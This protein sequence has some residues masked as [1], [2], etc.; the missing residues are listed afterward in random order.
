MIIDELREKANKLPLK[1]GVYIM[2]DRAGEVIYVGKA[3]LLKN[4]VTSYFRGESEGK[5]RALVQKIR[6]FN[7]IVAA[8]EFEALVL[9]N[10]LIKR[11]QPH[12]NILLKDS[13]AYP[14]V[15]ADIKSEYPRFSIVAKTANDGAKYFGP[16]GGRQATK[17]IIETLCK[18]LKIPT[19]Q[20]KFPRDIGKERPCL[21]SHMGACA[22]WCQPGKNADEYR[23]LFGQGIMFLEGRAGDL[24]AELERQMTAAADEL[25]FETAAVLRDR[26][27][28]V[29]M[30]KNRQNV[31]AAARADTD[32]VGFCRDVKCCFAVLHY[33]NGELSGKDVTLIDDSAETDAEIVSSLVR[34]YY[35]RRGAWP[36]VILLPLEIE[37]TEPLSRLL[38]EAAGFRV[39]IETPLRGDRRRLIDAARDNAKEECLRETTAYERGL[40]TLSWLANALNLPKE[41]ERIEAFDVSNT[42]NF[43][44]VAAMTV[45]VRARPL[46]RDYR[47]FRIG[48]DETAGVT[49]DDYGSMREAVKR[50]FAR[51]LANDEKFSVLPDLLL[52]DGGAEHAAAAEGV[53]KALS[54]SVP[55][56]GMV[57]DGRH[58]TRA[59]V[60]PTGAKT[61]ISGNPAV[62]SLIGSIQEETHRFAIEYHRG[63]RAKTIASGLEDIPGVGE[64]R[65]IALLAEFKTLKA[66]KA[67]DIDALSRAV[68][69]NTAKAIYEFYRDDN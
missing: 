48:R 25:R 35:A 14:F 67:A 28:A 21:N 16:Y 51:Y 17:D 40:K 5:T 54:L 38:S 24:A 20:R 2:L 15:R 31:I 19:C 58:R 8:S 34:Q 49:Q 1:P 27:R 3:K 63:L 26:L 29:S 52:I 33:T 30:L 66:I 10:S 7:V 68:P 42:G 46:K 53:L 9:E 62:F 56:F 4:R 11:H 59:L 65:R 13:K 61:A 43:G 22:G 6:D 45:F 39:S 55:V 50:R 36:K 69:K 18:A 23:E 41:P 44:I 32:A 12:Y 60:S 57:K 37:D 64:K 47:R